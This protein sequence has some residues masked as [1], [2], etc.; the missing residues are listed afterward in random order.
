MCHC[1]SKHIQTQKVNLKNTVKADNSELISTFTLNS[2]TISEPAE[3][4]NLLI[5]LLR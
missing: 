5:I 4:T 1:I 2:C 3:C